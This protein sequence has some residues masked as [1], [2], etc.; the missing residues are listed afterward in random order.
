MAKN[1]GVSGHRLEA[2]RKLVRS[3]AD[4]NATGGEYGYALKAAVAMPTTPTSTCFESTSL[5]LKFL[6]ENGANPG[7]Q[8]IKHDEDKSVQL[9]LNRGALT[10]EAARKKHLEL[11]V[12]LNAVLKTQRNFGRRR[13]SDTKA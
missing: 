12:P 7:A 9:L 8:A 1:P 13:V 2:K 6:L 5:I 3:G 11:R 10:Q 4:V